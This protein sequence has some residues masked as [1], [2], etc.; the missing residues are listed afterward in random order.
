[1]P[2]VVIGWCEHAYGIAGD[3]LGYAVLSVF[4]RA[5]NS[6][7]QFGATDRYELSHS[8]VPNREP[9]TNGNNGDYGLRAELVAR[10]IAKPSGSH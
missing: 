10:A 5:R 1:M 8:N 7:Q 9:L 3:V 2:I 6:L 4:P